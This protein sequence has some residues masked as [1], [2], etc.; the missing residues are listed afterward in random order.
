LEVISEAREDLGEALAYNPDF[1]EAIFLRAIWAWEAGNHVEA[2]NCASRLK[3][4][5]PF[6]FKQLPPDLIRNTEATLN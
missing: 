2:I 6:L 1:G 3:M 4:V 5:A